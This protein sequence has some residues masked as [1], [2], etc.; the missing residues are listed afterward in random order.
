MLQLLRENLGTEKQE[1][2]AV[3]VWLLEAA[4]ETSIKM[5]VPLAD[6]CIKKL[7]SSADGYFSNTKQTN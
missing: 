4:F 1:K 7:I 6:V 2:F 3:W 5:R